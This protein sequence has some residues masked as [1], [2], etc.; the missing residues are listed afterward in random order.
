MTMAT[1]LCIIVIA[2]FLAAMPARAATSI[3]AASVYAQSGAVSNAAN[4]LGNPD[5][6]AALVG[7][8]GELVLQYANPLTGGGVLASLLPGAG[9]NVIA[10]SVGEVL[11]G[12]ATFSGEFVLVDDGS[13]NPLGGDLAALCSGVSAT[14]CSLLRLRNA[15]SL[16]GSP[17]FSLDCVS[18]VTTAP[19]PSTWALMILGFAGLAWRLKEARK[20]GRSSAPRP[21]NWLPSPAGM[22]A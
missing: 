19:E 10:V 7:A 11:G 18:G 14:G 15:G 6:A 12:V 3:F 9:F 17:G 2:A 16:M 13:G 5:G 22:P 8:G 21:V 4:A 20:A 1:R